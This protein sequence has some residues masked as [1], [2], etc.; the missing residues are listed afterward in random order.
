VPVSTADPPSAA[1]PLPAVLAIDGGGSKTDVALVAEDGTLLCR[2]RGPATSAAARN[3]D[4]SLSVLGDLI[5]DAQRRAGRGG[6]PVARHTSAC[7]AD[8]DLPE[9][10]EQLARALRAKGWSLTTHA[11]NDT[12]AVLRAGTTQGWGVAV[13]CGS[14][15][16]CVGV[17]PDGRTTRFLAFG[18]VT[19]DWGGGDHLAKEIMWWAMRAED[20]RGARTALREAV[21][22][23][24]RAVRVRDVAVRYHFGRISPEGLAQLTHVLFQV[25]AAG[26]PVARS[27]VTRQAEEVILMAATAMRRLGLLEADTDVVL[28]GGIL[29]SRDPLLVSEIKARLGRAAPRAIPRFASLPPIAG[30]ALLGLDHVQ[31][32]AAAQQRLRGAFADEPAG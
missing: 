14:G 9:E 11:A 18:Q 15:I 23:H 32:S 24:F 26:D 25:A 2:V 29:A 6:N 12:F 8:A 28:G 30:A 4:A 16:N 7:L 21:V 1:E 20:G 5:T 19:G 27:L 3:L 22:A 10:E 31:A 17:A 13:T